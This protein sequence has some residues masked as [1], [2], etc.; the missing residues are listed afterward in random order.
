MPPSASPTTSRSDSVSRSARRPARTTGWSSTSR[1]RISSAERGALRRELHRLRLRRATPAT[2][3]AE[4]G[5]DE[6]LEGADPS[7]GLIASA[8]AAR[9]S[10]EDEVRYR[11]DPNIWDL[12]QFAS[13][14]YDQLV[15]DYLGWLRARTERGGLASSASIKAAR[16][17]LASF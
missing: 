14:S 8:G 15:S 11:V 7:Y 1:T 10:R 5:Q 13:I 12:P 4:A 16:D 6:G 2:A 9:T 3:S 17:T